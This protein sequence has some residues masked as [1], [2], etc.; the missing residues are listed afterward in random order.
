MS[1]D[2]GRH[3]DL[4]RYWLTQGYHYRKKNSAAMQ[5]DSVPYKQRLALEYN[6]IRNIPGY[7]DY[8][9]MTSDLVRWA[10][11]NNIAV[12]P[13]RGSAAGSLC[14]WFLRITEIDPLLYPMLFERFIS[15]DRTDLPDID[16]D[17]QDDRRAEVIAYAQNKYGS[18]HVGNILNFV[19]YKGKNSL[20]DIARVYHVPEWKIA[21]VK[22]KLVERNEGHPRFADT[23]QDTF[24]T[25][26]DIAALVEE[27]P[28][29]QYAT[30]LEGNYRNTSFH[31]AGVVIAS[32]PLN[33]I[34]ATYVKQ[35][36]KDSGFG[37][38]YDK[39]DSEYLGLLKIDFLSLTTLSGIAATLAA[40]GMDI[41]DLY[42]LPLDDPKVYQSF[43]KGDVLGIFQFEGQA[44][45]R[46]LKVMQ[47]TKFLELSDVNALSRPGGD[48][49][50]YFANRKR[51][52]AVWTH[53][54]L[55][56]HLGWTHGTIV[57]Q[58]Q[59]LLVLRDLGNFEPAQT[60]SIRKAISGKL[61]QSVFNAY[62]EQ[63]VTGAATHGMNRS[64]ALQVWS[65]IVASAD[66]SFNISHSVSYSLIAYWQMWLKVYHP[67][68]Y[69]G[70]LL[71]CPDDEDGKERRRR[72][73]VEAGRKGIT[74][75][76]PNLVHS[77]ENWTLVGDNLYAGWRAIK[78][79]GEKMAANIVA[80]Q[81]DHAAELSKYLLDY[82]SLVEIPGI[83]PGRVA[84][85]RQFCEGDDP[86]G[87]ERVRRTLDRIRKE[88]ECNEF[89][90]VPFPT[91]RSIDLVQPDEM[92]VFLG[93]LKGKNYKDTV[94]QRL[95]YG[96][97]GAT[98]E[99]ILAE[100]DSPHLTKYASL[101]AIDEYDEPVRIRIS[102]KMFPDVQGLI[103]KAKANADIVL[104]KGWVSDFGGT[105]VQA[106][107]LYVITPEGE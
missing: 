31:P 15:P 45:K 28:E 102:R 68:F 52:T 44:T 57:Y 17:F 24:N 76:P 30:Q 29:L 60:N 20:D 16:L 1:E 26:S 93:I 47:P 92:V 21:N 97:S 8:F 41:T 4:F 81:E 80:W 34:C 25:Y 94:E 100:L 67:E 13:G 6:I 82:D 71:K 103:A 5:A 101:D 63:F 62:S 73:I 54:I 107:E 95:K 3:E 83:G 90:W 61:D 7:I 32:V 58:E 106:K 89:Q 18:D 39:K 46:V 70:Q 105:A 22:G 72:L 38:A 42:N 50:A 40:I 27:T 12:G 14:C 74:V 11:N 78:G 2:V 91:H 87:V 48:D 51:G 85:I 10:K 9:L 84:V 19:R 79:V 66:Y 53:P 99:S 86:F 69:L 37:V 33:D 43:C 98:R 23:L 96:P 64:D 55:V 104:V 59:I 88:L 36:G 75:H 77:K 35:S 49:T 65:K 56:Q